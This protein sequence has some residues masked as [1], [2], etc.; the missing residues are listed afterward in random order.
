MGNL[1]LFLIFTWCQRIYEGFILIA[2][3][4]NTLNPIFWCLR[5][6]LQDILRVKCINNKYLCQK[7]MDCVCVT[8]DFS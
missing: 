4:T 7:T 6:F 3:A 8:K 1:E 5:S 2:M